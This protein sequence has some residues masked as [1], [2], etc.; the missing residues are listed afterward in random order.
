MCLKTKSEYYIHSLNQKNGLFIPKDRE[1]LVSA[2]NKT[3][4]STQSS[5][6]D[7]LFSVDIYR[8]VEACA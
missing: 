5:N 7:L 2:E 4:T 6:C 8:F 1:F 3:L